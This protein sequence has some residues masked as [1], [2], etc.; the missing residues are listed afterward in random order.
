MTIIEFA[1][2]KY[3]RLFMCVTLPFGKWIY[4]VGAPHAKI[5]YLIM[6]GKKKCDFAVYSKRLI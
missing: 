2:D 3:Q 1:N 4:F 6:R 5:P